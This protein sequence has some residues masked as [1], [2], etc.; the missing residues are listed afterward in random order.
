[1][2][3][4]TPNYFVLNSYSENWENKTLF[5]NKGFVSLT[6]DFSFNPKKEIHI[7]LRLFSLDNNS[8]KTEDA[9][10]DPNSL[11][12]FDLDNNNLLYILEKDA[13]KIRRL[14]L[15]SYEQDASS[16]RDNLMVDEY[17]IICK[18]LDNPKSI[19]VTKRHIYVLDYSTLYVYSKKNYELIKTIIF[20][21]GINIFRITEDEELVFYSY[22]DDKT[23][24]YKKNIAWDN[25]SS[26][27]D[28][29]EYQVIDLP[30]DIKLPQNE[31]INENDKINRYGL[32]GGGDNNNA[33]RHEKTRSSD[34]Y[35]VNDDKIIENIIDIA[36]NNKLNILYVLTYRN[37]YVYDFRGKKIIP[38]SNGKRF[39]NPI[40][41][42]ENEQEDFDPTCI[43]ID[44]ENNDVYIGNT[45]NQDELAFPRMLKNVLDRKEDDKNAKLQ[46]IGFQGQSRKLFLTR[47]TKRNKSYRRLLVINVV[48]DKNINR[49]D[50]NDN[51]NGKVEKDNLRRTKNQTTVAA[52]ISCEI[53]EESPIYRIKST[54][55]ITTKSLDSLNEKTRWYKITMDHD[56][57][58]NTFVK[59]SY[60]CSNHKKRPDE[61]EWIS[62]S[63]N[64]KN[65]LILDCVGRYLTLKVDLSSLNE[66]ESPRFNKMI[67]HFSVPTYMRFLPDLYQE[68]EQSKIFLEKFLCI[69]Q[70]LFEETE[71]KIFSFTRHLD[72]K[73][74]P[75]EFLPWL[76]SWLSVSFSDGWSSE[77][78]RSFLERAPEI[79]RKQGTR[80]GLE[81]I[82]TTYLQGAE[83]R[84]PEKQSQS[85][86]NVKSID[87]VDNNKIKTQI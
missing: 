26:E 12:S 51:T 24:L 7:S 21:D 57:P 78:V 14:S 34:N 40:D 41:I 1:M 17:I 43:A 23:K 30:K 58:P 79:F 10:T 59:L 70:T 15:D 50:I 47:V 73:A 48:Q 76:S 55:T 2:E 68:D 64:S 39:L 82:L 36:I 80:E 67:V 18:G 6:P 29:E 33:Y 44:E 42:R 35:Y 31:N 20:N 84:N 71:N 27:T 22:S 38:D 66:K 19:S 63:V 4:E 25:D 60:M 3:N 77:S 32:E 87:R 46:K 9:P 11:L 37:L 49:N 56:I 45:T 85:R 83:K 86:Q 75:E 8:P 13:K 62:G 16:N 69:F 72:V 81:E 52:Q 74:T 61:D 5:D 65:I 28:R 54:T 53:L